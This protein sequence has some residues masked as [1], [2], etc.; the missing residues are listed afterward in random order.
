MVNKFFFFNCFDQQK[1]RKNREKLPWE[2][3]V[4]CQGVKLFVLK[5]VTITTVPTASVATVT[6]KTLVTKL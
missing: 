1:H 6:I 2:Y 5:Y 4:C 3:L